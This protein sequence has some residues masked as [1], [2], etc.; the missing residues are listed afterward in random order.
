AKP[1]KRQARLAAIDPLQGVPAPRA[2][3][4]ERGWSA[5]VDGVGGTGVI[6]IGAVPG[7]AAHLEGKGVGI[8]DMAGLA[9]KGGAVHSH[10]RI[11]ATPAEVDCIHV[12]AGNAD[13]VFGGDL[14]VTG[15]SKVLT[16]V[17]HGH[18]RCLVNTAETMHGYFTRSADFRLPTEAMKQAISDA[19]GPEQ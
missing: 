2:Y 7:M 14:V 12:A 6:T 3:P 19:A 16:T 9:Q 11:A 4:L 17:R 8:I 5:I 15:S 1:R 13:F 10:L 18:T